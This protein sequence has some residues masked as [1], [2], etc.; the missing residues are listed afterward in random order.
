MYTRGLGEVYPIIHRGLGEVYPIIHPRVWEAC[1][2]DTYPGMVGMQVRHLPGYGRV[3][4]LHTA[5]VG[6]GGYT[7]LCT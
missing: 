2:L 4:S 1:R 5:R 3:V 6:M 7:P